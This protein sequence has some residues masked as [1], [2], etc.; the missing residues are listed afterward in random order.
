M[1]LNITD[2]LFDAEELRHRYIIGIDLGT[3]NSAVAYI[4]LREEGDGRRPIHIVKIPQLVAPGDL[5]QRHM[6][7]SFLYLP[8]AY[9]LPPGSTALPWDPDRTYVVGELAREQGARVPGRLVS[10]AKSW[11]SHAGVDRTAPILPWGAKAEI[12][13]VSPV[14]ASKRYLQHIREAWDAQIAAGQEESVFNQ[15]LIILTVPASFD[16][17]ARELT[18]T[19]AHQAGIPRAILLEEPLAAFYNWLSENQSNWQA[20]MADRQLI[21]VCDVGG[22][23]T[24]FTI[25]GVREGEAGLRFDRLAVGE[26]LMLGGDNMDMTLG[27]HLETK[28][29][30][31][32]GKLDAE[33]WHQLVHQCRKAKETLLDPE[34]SRSDQ[35]AAMDITV[36]GTGGQVIGGT[37]KGSLT[38]EEVQ[39]LI[40]DGFFPKV[41][42]EEIPSERRRA[43]LTELGLPYVQDPAIT[44]HLAAFWQRFQT[45]LQQ[46]M[47]RDAVYP[48][49]V[50]FNGGTLIPA[51]IRERLQ[52]VIQAWF[53]PVA[54]EAWQPVELCNPRPELAV[55]LGAAYYGLVRLGQGVR[56]GSG[57]P[58]AYYVGV[59][60]ED[61][62]AS[63]GLY[64]A[65]CL[66][67]RGTEEGFET[68]LD[69]PAFIALTNQPVAFQLFTS[70]TRLGDR[71]GDVVRLSPDEISALP[72]IRTVLRYGKG[73][74]NSIPV[75]L[76]V[77]LT[78]VGTLELW[79]QSQQT[80]HRW[81]LQFDVRQEVEPS[82]SPSDLEETVDQATIEAAQAEIRQTFQSKVE[83]L[84]AT[85][86]RGEHSPEALRKTLEDILGMRRDKWPTY[87]IRQLAD[88]LLECQEGRKRSPEHEKRW[89]NMLGFC[90]RP[91]FGDPVDEWRMQQA[92][93]LY[94]QGLA[95]PKEAQCRNEWW[96]FWR[97]VAGGLTAGRQMQMYQQV[98]PYLQG[99]K[100]SKQ[101][102]NPMFPKHLRPGEDIE[103]WMTLASFERLPAEAKVEIG[104]QLLEKFRRK[105]PTSRELWAL[106]RLGS[107]KTI[108]GPLDRLVPPSEAVVWLETLLALDLEP[109][110]HVA[111]CLVLLAQRTGDRARDIS[112]ETRDQVVRWL[113][114]LPDAERFQELLMNHESSLDQAEQDW[115]FGEALPAGLVLFSATE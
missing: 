22:G 57:S 95:F 106:S 38:Q 11:L 25:V 40:I 7:P 64:T 28:L 5:K 52:D 42:L 80:G 55:A 88:A 30:S 77:R 43:G 76:V 86:V 72:P 16:E 37:I 98:W 111:Y 9:D 61:D 103:I 79:C 75:Q 97:R 48:D 92:W 99:G 91:G 87:L 71:L 14:E 54:G 51:S 83:T 58:R 84:H 102:P 96:V 24:D 56:V 44:R 33:R 90:L 6:L 10:S 26:H 46:E 21:L 15:Q 101:K 23:T 50:L 12:P 4:D 82:S 60:T 93:K 110:Q 81:Q 114:Q 107:R 113:A 62:G 27:R 31:H 70:S 67:P 109:T 45:F 18:I 94:F 108:Y 78:A 41:S 39:Q 115:I 104:R 68:Q 20:Q 3:T 34:E 29:L 59:E 112:E 17:V 13:K 100:T 35:P 49:F 2:E 74:V 73:V 89:L 36:M 19:A 85:S 69:E 32:P 53:Q 105:Q 8:G 66:V 63:E 47:G 1:N 65:V